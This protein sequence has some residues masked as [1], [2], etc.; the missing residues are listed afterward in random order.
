MQDFPVH[1]PLDL[2]HA[3][4]LIHLRFEKLDAEKF[5][6]GL[7]PLNSTDF[8]ER[9]RDLPRKMHRYLFQDILSNAG[10][11]RSK[12]DLGGGYIF[13]GT[14]QRFRGFIPDEIS[15]GVKDACSHLK[16]NDPDPI[17][18]VVHFYQH[19]VF[20]HPFYDANGRIG[21]FISTIYLDYHGFHISW[22]M[23][24]E[25]QRWLKKLNSC[26]LRVGQENFEKYMHRLRAHWKKNIFR[27]SDIDPIPNE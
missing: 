22:R 4:K 19:F 23:M 13:F 2:D 5:S 21:R 18:S 3:S 12:E 7:L 1:L 10:S 26:H 8:A 17:S 11:Y 24:H 6:A 9:F 27:K 15:A 20:V 25:N 16:K 14:Q